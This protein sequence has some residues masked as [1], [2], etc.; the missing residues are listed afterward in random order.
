[1]LQSLL[2]ILLTLALVAVASI[3]GYTLWTRYMDAPWTRDGRVR[4]D[5]ISVAPDVAGIVTAVAVVDNQE[6]HKGD[7]LF[8]VDEARY[9][10]A[11]TQAEA[12]LEGARMEAALKRDEAQ[13]RAS[14]DAVVVSSEN[15]QASKSAAST[16]GARVQVAQSVVAG[17]QLNLE[18]TRVLAPQDG[19]VV[20]LNVHPGDY[21]V[22]GRPLIA[23][24][25]RHSFRIE[26]YFEETKLTNIHPGD[27]AELRLLGSNLKISGHVESLARA[28]SEPDVA[29]LLSSVNPTFHWVRLAQRI[30]VRIRIDG[31]PDGLVL[32]SG[33]TC[34]VVVRPRPAPSAAQGAH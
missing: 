5:V 16:A 2:R 14:L 1:M 29:G 19:Y 28:I 6:V 7:L 18:R 30:P 17:A 34:T 23:V 25:D 9:R 12:S 22:V 20:N 21:A 15:Q 13:R 8:S 3:V 10:V 33:M 11:L 27:V 26:A 32:T 4:A 31:I 24:V